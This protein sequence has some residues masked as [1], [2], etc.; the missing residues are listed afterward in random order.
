[1]NTTEQSRFDKLYHRHLRA[2][3]L[4]GMSDKT[5]DVYARAVRR[6][7]VVQLI[8]PYHLSAG[9]LRHPSVF[10][11]DRRRAHDTGVVTHECRNHGRTFLR[12]GAARL[13]QSPY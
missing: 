8:V 9:L 10:S 12:R 11:I 6:V 7:S 3:K 2:L 4:R 13:P 5:I 1:M